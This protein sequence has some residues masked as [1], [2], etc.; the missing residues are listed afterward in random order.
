MLRRALK[1]VAVNLL[2]LLGVAVVLELMF[3]TWFSS[4]PLEVLNIQ[5]NQTIRVDAAPLYAGGHRFKYQ[6]NRWGFRGSNVDPAK[7]DIVTIGGST[8]NQIYLPQ[9]QTW[10][11]VMERRLAALGHPATIANAGVD[12]QSSAGMLFDV[13]QWLTNVPGLKPKIVLGYVGVNDTAVSFLAIDHLAYSGKLKWLRDHSALWRFGRVVDGLIRARAA[14]LTHDRVDF[15]HAAWT[16]RPNFPDNHAARSQASTEA[17]A[18]RLN[19]LADAIEQLG[20]R[21]VFVTQWR[22]DVRVRDGKLEGLA[23]DHGLNALDEAR[24][25]AAFN[26]TL[27]DVCARRHIACFDLASD[28][29]FANGDFYDLL[30]NTPQGAE[31]VGTYLADKLNEGIWPPVSASR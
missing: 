24:L 16:D 1:V 17:Y 3:G 21:P 14:R 2:V 10:Q 11:A 27:L 12:G 22:G 4:D 19:A 8:T 23:A 30:H 28:V 15:D 25:L 5:R 26:K 9:D 29:T 20:A 18:Q 7:I 13:Q 31:K 6:R